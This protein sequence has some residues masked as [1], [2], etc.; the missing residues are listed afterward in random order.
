MIVPNK[1]TTLDQSLLALMPCLLK[2]ISEEISI[3]ELFENLSGLFEDVE[4]FT[5]VLDMLFVLGR[6][7][8]NTLRKTVKPC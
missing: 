4:E 8:I 3:T 2:E 1:F 6:V 5:L 7:E